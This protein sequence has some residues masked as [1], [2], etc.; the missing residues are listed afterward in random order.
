M[1][2]SL[3]K[4]INKKKNLL[5]RFFNQNQLLVIVFFGISLF[6]ILTKSLNTY[7]LTQYDALFTQYVI[8]YRV[9]ALTDYF[10]FVTHVGDVYGYIA[11]VFI[12]AVALNFFSKNWKYIIQ[13]IL[14]LIFSA[15]LNMVLKHIINRAR[16][17]TEHLVFVE[18]LSYPSGHAMSAI[19]FY[20][21]LIYLFYSLKINK[22]IKIVTIFM[23]TLL[24][25]SIGISRIYLG[26]H[27]PSDILGG[28]I[29]GTITLVCCIMVF[30]HIGF[31]KPTP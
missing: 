1:F 19:A 11:V 27:F 26:V 6:L 21:Y 10:V 30:N 22:L 24:I 29:A 18:T 9:N 14:V 5:P 25:V 4:I 7:I 20:G 15:L 3:A 2:K 17:T 31:L 28:F 12:C 13:I 8:S 23:L 16:P